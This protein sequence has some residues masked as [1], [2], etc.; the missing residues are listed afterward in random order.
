MQTRETYIIEQIGSTL[1]DECIT[2]FQEFYERKSDY[3]LIMTR[4]CFVLFKIFKPILS[5]KNIENEYGTIITDKALELYSNDITN[6]LKSSD[7]EDDTKVL[8]IDDIIIF[9]RTIKNTIDDI[10]Q[11]IDEAERELY[12]NKL[13]AFC[14]YKK[15]N[16]E[17]LKGAEKRI[18]FA[19]TSSHNSNW[20]SYSCKFSSIIK[21][22]PVPN[23]SYVISYKKDL[24]RDFEK[25]CI[26]K[27]ADNSTKELSDHGV[28]TVVATTEFPNNYEWNS[29]FKISGVRIHFHHNMEYMVLSPLVVLKDLTANELCTMSFEICNKLFH[30]NEANKFKELLLNKNKRVFSTKLRLLIL[31]FSHSLL[32]N[33]L[34]AHR[35]PVNNLTYFDYDE[36]LGYNFRKEFSDDFAILHERIISNWI[37]NV[38]F[39]GDPNYSL[40]TDEYDEKVFEKAIIDNASAIS[41]IQERQDEF[42]IGNDIVKFMS[43]IDIG[44]AALKSKLDKKRGLY[45]SRVYS[46]EQAFRIMFDE[47]SEIMPYL[48]FLENYAISS[49]QQVYILYN[50]F[51]DYISDKNDGTNGFTV[52]DEYSKKLKRSIAILEENNHLISDVYVDDP[53][54]YNINLIKQTVFEFIRSQRL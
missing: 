4:R 6:A 16:C 47:F 48:Y 1:Y 49:G 7:D 51:I 20:K 34:N 36:I 45:I 24:S 10:L 35:L 8:L 5:Y 42:E 40:K 54:L 43:F 26:S 28:K 53:T 18:I 50:N 3:K 37:M 13:L 25:D 23:T 9:G 17:H 30:N 14:I 2:F 21:A 22:L 15:P 19:R 11:D 44:K 38:Q 31:I 46:G 39:N 29:F 32:C 52:S 27:Y 41:G 33:F 12:L